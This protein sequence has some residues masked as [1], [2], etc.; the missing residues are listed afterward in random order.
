MSNSS[1]N[2]LAKH[3]R[4][5]VLYVKLPS[6]GRW[7]AEG[8]ISIPVT[9]DLPVFSMTAKDEITM[10]TPDALMN[11]SST[12][13]VIEICCPS[14]KDA[15]KMPAV[16]LDT[17]LIAIRIASYGKEMHF[18]AVCPHCTTQVEKA[19]D[20]TVMLGKI[21]CADWNQPVQVDGLEIVLKPQSYEDY[22]KN[23][24]V[25]YEEQR[26][27]QLVQDENLDEAEK[28]R[29]FDVLFQKLIETSIAQIS[30]SIA[31]IR[32]EDGVLVTEPEFIREFL[33]NC[34]KRIWEHIKARL[35]QIRDETSWN[36]IN[37][38]CENPECCK[39]YVTP[40]VFEQSNFFA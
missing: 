31:G 8:S 23:N 4:Q 21:T 1:N 32:T 20:L 7:W 12:V 40:F 19:I 6:Q 27:L 13:H 29:Q 38:T 25:N 17:L 14:V 37:L 18:T 28:S 2:P 24:M 9:G 15:W 33:D 39:D 10:K 35:D 16:D 22:N 30:R 34:D 11:G 26:L 3:F 36:Q 5:P